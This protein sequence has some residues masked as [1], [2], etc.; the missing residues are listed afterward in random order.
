M[1]PSKY[2]SRFCAFLGPLA[3]VVAAGDASAAPTW[4]E[5]AALTLSP[6]ESAIN[7]HL[8]TCV[9][10]RTKAGDDD[11]LIAGAYGREGNAGAVYVWR[12]TQGA[13]TFAQK[14]VATDAAANAELGVS[15]AVSGDRLVVGAPGAAGVGA[16]YVFSYAGGTF[17]FEKKLVAPDPDTGDR[18]GLSVAIDGDTVVVGAESKDRV[19][20]PGGVDAGMAY[21]F[22]RAAGAFGAGVPIGASD[23]KAGDAFGWSVAI[24]GSSILVGAYQRNQFRGALYPFEKSGATWTP[25]TA[26][27]ASDA[28]PGD[29]LGVSLTIHGTVAVAGA[30]GKSSFAGA[31]Y[32]FTK[33]GAA[34]T[35]KQALT[36]AGSSGLGRAVG[37]FDGAFLIGGPQKSGGRG[38]VLVFQ[39]D[40]IVLVPP[41]IVTSDAAASD[42]FG[43]A[44]AMTGSVAAAGAPEASGVR[45]R[46]YALRFGLA[47]GETCKTDADCIHAFCIDGV[48]CDSSCGGGKPNDCMACSKASGGA[49]DGTCGPA[50]PS[51][52]CR[53][54]KG[55]C[56]VDDHCDPTQTTCPADAVARN[57]APCT[58]GACVSGACVLGETPT[59]DAGV[60]VS[61]PADAGVDAKGCACGTVVATRASWFPPLGVGLA[62][63]MV[64]RR[65]LRK[66]G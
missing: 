11:L 10:V 32:V 33:G 8:G 66:K 6:A 9:A 46:V 61:G 2:A 17:T 47:N 30:F 13:W 23:A 26:I 40:P 53:S 62:L 36:S 38:E 45:G 27:T 20:V 15:C 28:A 12:R 49:V 16:A 64:L 4:R 19:G 22:T 14:L 39:K 37:T 57:G 51:I 1:R 18:F 54:A 41:A 52:V 25:Q 43:A 58:S 35:E 56:D 55:E 48:C 63:A 50:A 65:A 3:L 5:E 7:D 42:T 44:L 31:A 59:D 24:S 34:W 60:P 29:Q 21:V